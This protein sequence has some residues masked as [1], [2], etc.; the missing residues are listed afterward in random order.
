MNGGKYHCL[1]MQWQLH[2]VKQW[3][4]ILRRKWVVCQT[5]TLVN[6]S[7]SWQKDPSTALKNLRKM[8]I[9]NSR[10]LHCAQSWLSKMML[11]VNVCIC[12]T[13]ILTEGTTTCVFSVRKMIGWYGILTIRNPMI[14]SH[15]IIIH[16]LCQSS[17]MYIMF[18][19]RDSWTCHF[20]G[21]LWEVSLS[22][23]YEFIYFMYLPT[24]ENQWIHWFFVEKIY[25]FIY[26]IY[27]QLLYVLFFV[28]V[29]YLVLMSS[30]LQ[31]IFVTQ[32]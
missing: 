4:V 31:M 28:G 2:H 13:R 5:P 8:L 17:R 3:T 9:E 19:L 22:I 1:L 30:S 32:W 26:S 29:V 25:D 11:P 21:F 6:L 18:V 20:C 24:T 14:P 16:S 10:I 12:A 7:C 15:Q 27:S 23:I